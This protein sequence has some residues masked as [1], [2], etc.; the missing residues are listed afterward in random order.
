MT[1]L[2]RSRCSCGLL[3]GS[4]TTRR[5]AHA[6]A[7]PTEENQATA[8]PSNYYRRSPTASSNSSGNA[9]TKGKGKAEDYTFPKK[10]RMGGEPDP[11]EI[12]GVDRSAP[13][14]EVK[15]QCM[16]PPLLVVRVYDVRCETNVRLQISFTTSSGLITSFFIT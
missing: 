11:F 16:F 8:G 6:A 12:M 2:A 9:S 1:L 13:Q 10:G 7:Q 5:S 3:R 4:K 14:S 15:K